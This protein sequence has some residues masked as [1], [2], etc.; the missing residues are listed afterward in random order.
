[1]PDRPR[2]LIVDDEAAQ[3][4][5]LESFL[6]PM[7]LDAVGAAS[8]EEALE[9]IGKEELSMVLLDV[10]LPGM[11]GLDALPQIHSF[12]PE[13][14]VLLITAYG[15]LR[16]AVAAVKG[17]AVDYLVKPV[18][19]DELEAVIA[20][21]LGT[22]EPQSDT[23]RRQLPDLPEDVVFVSPAMHH[24]AET[25]AVVAQSNVPVLVMGDSGTGKE[26]IAQLIHRWSTRSDGPLVAA[27]CAGLPESLIESELFGHTKGA[28]T[29]AEQSRQGLFRAADGEL[30]SST[31]SANSR[32]TCNRNS[33]AP[34][35]QAR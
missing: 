18:D 31:K 12:A 3:R 32:F 10:R 29:G 26:V 5:L 4:D 6:T 30:C 14:P 2:I 17:G 34:S 21:T 9:R 15:D 22:S 13:L 27:N 11:S 19:L 20:D 24:V 8:A 25:V 28:F 7:G 1:M 16:Q 33:S 35:R 23:P